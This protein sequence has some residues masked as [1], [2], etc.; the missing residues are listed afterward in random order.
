[1]VSQQNRLGAFIPPDGSDDLAL[2]RY[3][4]EESIN[5]LYQF[6]V[7][8]LSRRADIDPDTLLGLNASVR[9]S[10]VNPAHPDRYIDG[11]MTEIRWEGQVEGGHVHVLTLRPWL[12]L[13]S[14]RQNQKIFHNMTV[15]EILTDLFGTYGFSHSAELQQS[16]PT[17]EYTVQHHES[18]LDFAL[19]LMSEYGINYRFK[20]ERHNHE[21]VLFDETDS[22][23]MVPGD[24]RRY[25]MTDRQHR[26]SDE[27][28]HD[29]VSG[30][31]MT[32]GRIA[33]TDY[34]FTAPRSAMAT[35][36]GQGSGY[37]HGE[38]EAFLYPGRYPD[39]SQGEALSRT[40]VQ[41]LAM[42]DGRHRVEGDCAG[43]VAGMRLTVLD[44]PDSA[45]DGKTFAVLGC[46]HSYVSEGYRSGPG[47]GGGSGGGQDS[48]QGSYELIAADR[49]VRPPAGEIRPRISGP[50]TAVVVGAGEIDCD[51]YGRIL[52]KFHWDR[53]AAHSMRCR[54]AQSWAGAGWGGIVIP[55]VGMEVIVDFIDGDPSR[56]LVTG[57]VYNADNMPPFDLPAQNMVSGLKSNST[58]GGGGYN[59]LSFDDTTGKEL[60]RLHAQHDLEGHVLHDAV[61]TI[62]HDKLLTVGRNRAGTIGKDDT[63]EVGQ[64]LTVTAGTS[65]TFK[66]GMSSIVMT[67]DTITLKAPT[68]EVK[69]G[70]TFTSS[71]GIDSKHNAGLTFDIKGAMVKINS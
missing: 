11:L 66:V 34:N 5:G 56:P 31:R 12:W 71:A 67:N 68:V 24:S 29:W 42:G 49:P 21:L 35:E 54:V 18:D 65:I 23:P 37:A 47:S 40:R 39:R 48:F 55:R 19:R 50:Q 51:E 52:V 70:Q 36:E 45:I 13:L 8:C 1:M 26:D 22:L 43:L 15:P 60:V 4:G 64:T 58:P 59:E 28:L 27:H 25:R 32:T 46:R 17:L 62:D 57:C 10:T 53:D 44:H 38:I 7:S 9:L 6:E 3:S 14:L 33:L 69:A 20:H 63:L 61:W 2:L 30:R 41:Q 16:Y